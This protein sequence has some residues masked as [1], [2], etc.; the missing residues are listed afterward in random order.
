MKVRYYTREYLRDNFE[1]P[2]SQNQISKIFWDEYD[3]FLERIVTVDVEG[4]TWSYIPHPIFD[5][6]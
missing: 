1:F 5:K 3:N 4:N 2:K 6:R